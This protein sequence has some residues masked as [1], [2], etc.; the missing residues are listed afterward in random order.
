[1]ATLDYLK[2][3]EISSQQ[4]HHA[5]TAGSERLFERPSFTITLWAGLD[6]LS[7]VVAGF[8]AIRIRLEP[9]APASHTVLGHLE[10]AAP[11]TSMTYLLVFGLYLVVF[12][13]IYGLYR[14][15]DVRSGLNEQRLT[16]Q[17]TLT[18]GL[19]LCG[20]LYV[21][22]EYSVSRI[23]VALTILM[24]LVFF[25]GSSKP[26]LRLCRCNTFAMSA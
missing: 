8:I 3:A 26:A 24:T 1:M 23:V 13:R 18:A 16:V 11:L 22:K 19:M 21:M 14:S 4:R 9:V 7:A 12:A 10:A 6:F 2:Q 25:T 5:K 20:T 15:Q 17:T